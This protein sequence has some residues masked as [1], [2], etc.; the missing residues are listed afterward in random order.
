MQNHTLLK[1][2]QNS[3]DQAAAVNPAQ[4]NTL[5]SGR[6]AKRENFLRPVKFASSPLLS[7]GDNFRR[8]PCVR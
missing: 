7:F 6:L 5:D 3:S 4:I 2:H 1:I 8:R